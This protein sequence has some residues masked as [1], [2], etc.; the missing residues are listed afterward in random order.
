MV[1]N[2]L[3]RALGVVVFNVVLDAFTQFLDI[4]R[5]VDTIIQTSL[6]TES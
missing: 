3:M 4:V 6:E 5:G 1:L 2:A